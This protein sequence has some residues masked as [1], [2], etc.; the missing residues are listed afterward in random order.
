M[1]RLLAQ[2]AFVHKV[3]ENAEREDGHC[4][5]VAAVAGVA[6]SELGEDLVVVFCRLEGREARVSLSCKVLRTRWLVSWERDPWMGDFGRGVQVPWRAIVLAGL[7]A[8]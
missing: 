8:S 6:A 7:L 4:Q 5:A 1:R 2:R 3:A